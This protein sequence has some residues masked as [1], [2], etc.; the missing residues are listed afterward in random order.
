VRANGIVVAPN[1][2][3]TAK[4][5]ILGREDTPKGGSS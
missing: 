4:E 5:Q 3:T 2:L 1:K